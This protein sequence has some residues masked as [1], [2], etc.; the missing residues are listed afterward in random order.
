MADVLHG[1]GGLPPK[2]TVQ[3][4]GK[5]AGTISPLEGLGSLKELAMVVSGS[6]ASVAMEALVR[7]A[8]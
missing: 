4:D 1:H 7:R 8:R 5:A 6:L 3:A 2:T